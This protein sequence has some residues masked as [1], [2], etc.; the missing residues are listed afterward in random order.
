MSGLSNDDGN[1]EVRAL[2]DLKR[3]FRQ[4]AHDL[5]E[6]QEQLE[7]GLADNADKQETLKSD[8]IKQAVGEAE[9]LFTEEQPTQE[10][11]GPPVCANRTCGAQLE[12]KDKYCWQ[13][14]TPVEAMTNV[15]VGASRQS[16]PRGR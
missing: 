13:C 14:A 16:R 8:Y 11:Q 1:G 2:V 12:M 5:K 3:R 6:E 9:D 4:E 10:T 15:V 7:A